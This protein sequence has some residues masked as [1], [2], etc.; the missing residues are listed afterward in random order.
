MIDIQWLYRVDRDWLKR[1]V[2]HFAK[3]GL[4]FELHCWNEETEA[5]ALAKSIAHPKVSDWKHG[6]Y[7]EGVVTQEN[8]PVL[9]T[10]S[11]EEEAT[12]FFD[13][14]IDGDLC[15][16]HWGNEIYVYKSTSAD[17]VLKKLLDEIKDRATVSESFGEMQ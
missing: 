12:P 16:E 13:I 8:I 3:P 10:I 4:S 2:R 7:Y 5:I 9:A 11:D 14:L 15:C 6:V 17:P 1:F